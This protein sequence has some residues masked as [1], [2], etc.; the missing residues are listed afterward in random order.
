MSNKVLGVGAVAIALILGLYGA[1]RPAEKIVQ[2]ETVETKV[3]SVTGPDSFFPC[4]THDG[5]QSCFYRSGGLNNASTTICSTKS[6]AATSTLLFGSLSI[7]T[8]TTT[9][10]AYEIGKDATFA[11]TTT[12]LAYTTAAAGKLALVTGYAATS[13]GYAGDTAYTDENNPYI[14]APNQYLNWKYGGALGALNVLKGSC[15][16]YFRVL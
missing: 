16:A 10:V 5:L 11:A 13:T 2:R 9:S 4:E 3:G 12:R 8:G 1:F 15:T 7:T 14:F 6:P